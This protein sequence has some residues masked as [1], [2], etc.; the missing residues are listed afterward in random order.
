MME[1][2]KAWLVRSLLRAKLST[3]DIY[4][5]ASHQADL[6]TTIRSVD[7][8][9]IKSALKAKLKDI[10]ATLSQL[11]KEGSRL[12]NMIKFEHNELHSTLKQQMS[13]IKKKIRKE[14]DDRIKKFSEKIE[15]L[16]KKQSVFLAPQTPIVPKKTVPPKFL[17]EYGDLRIFSDPKHFPKKE[18]LIGPFIGDKNIKLSRGEKKLLSRDPKYALRQEVDK[19]DFRIEIEKMNVK[20]KYGAQS[21]KEKEM[22]TDGEKITSNKSLT[23]DEE[24]KALWEEERKRIVFDPIINKINLNNRRPTDYKHNKRIILPRPATTDIEFECEK[25]RRY[26]LRTFS[27]FKKKEEKKETKTETKE[28]KSKDGLKYD[29]LT[30]SEMKGLKSLKKRVSNGEVVITTTDKSGRMAILTQEQYIKSGQCHTDKDEKLDWGRI[31]YIQNQVNSHTWWFSSILGNAINTDSA[32]MGKNIQELS[33]Q[34][35]EM[36]LLIKDHKEWKEDDNKPIPS[37]PVLSGNN[38]LN[39]HLSE[40]LSEVLE[41]ITTRIGGAEVTSSEEAIN[42]ITSLNELIRNGNNWWCEKKYNILGLIGRPDDEL[43]SLLSQLENNSNNS[44]GPEQQRWMDSDVK[45]N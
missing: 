25:R 26:Y 13:P 6:R 36:S 39:T 34:I 7:W 35:P 10:M 19:T 8:Q 15:H 44:L 30:E 37:R 29:N 40:L 27:T 3:W 14:R 31:Q 38:C 1:D 24:L 41:P 4:K 11:R 22:D 17:A 42:K 20:R 43:T 12:E 33:S 23:P 5:F 45:K 9:T 16:R 32:R 28:N 2:T 21:E 18:S